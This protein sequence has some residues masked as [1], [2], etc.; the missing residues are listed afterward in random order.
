MATSPD[1]LPPNFDPLAR[2]Y[3]WMEYCSFGPALERCRFHFLPQCARAQQALIFGDGDGRFTARLLASNRTVQ[4]DAVDAST[5]MLAELRRRVTET[6]PDAAQRLR[7][8]HADVRSFS[9]DRSGYDLVV[10]H[11][12]LDCLTE[13][14]IENLVARI[15]PHL[16]FDAQWVISEFAVPANGWRRPA[17]RLLI[18]FLY[19]AFNKITQLRVQRLPDYAGILSRYHLCC[20]QKA[21]FLGNLLAAELW[22][23]E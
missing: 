7:T 3:R 13:Q 17:A 22:N 21:A 8:F 2:I 18:R 4:V 10:S 15:L 9:P 19:F 5:A 1:D 12:F 23:R 20:R 11:F 6:T 14:E 16:A